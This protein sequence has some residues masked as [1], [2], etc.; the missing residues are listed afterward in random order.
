LESLIGRE[1]LEDEG[2]DGRT[3][4]NLALKEITWGCEFI[5]SGSG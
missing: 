4:L 1:H 3:T 5:S 2:V